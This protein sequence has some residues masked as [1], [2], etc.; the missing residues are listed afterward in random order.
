MSTSHALRATRPRP[1]G[2]V[3]VPVQ[4]GCRSTGE[5]P[6][7]AS[8]ID[9]PLPNRVALCIGPPGQRAGRA[10][11]GAR[12]GMHGDRP[13]G[14][15]VGCG[16]GVARLWNEVDDQIRIGA[17]HIAV[18][19][20]AWNL[21]QGNLAY[22]HALQG[23][24]ILERHGPTIELGRALASA[25]ASGMELADRRQAIAMLRRSLDIPDSSV[26]PMRSPTRSTPW[27]ARSSPRA[28]STTVSCPSSE[29]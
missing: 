14:R 19:H 15:G 23:V 8:R 18:D 22:Q 27:A 9:P 4:R 28:R 1:T 12:R 3:G 20:I 11:R 26:T 10:F 13:D 5:L 25:G 6:R 21:G 2:R 7:I 17:A 16:R 24:E 29:R